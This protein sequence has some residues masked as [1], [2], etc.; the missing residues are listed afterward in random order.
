MI[1]CVF[2][3]GF[4]DISDI[5]IARSWVLNHLVGQEVRVNCH[6]RIIIDN[7]CLAMLGGWCSLSEFLLENLIFNF[8][9]LLQLSLFFCIFGHLIKHT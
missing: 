6:G 1:L 2:V 3:S 5:G 8:L 7:S 4:F 9:S